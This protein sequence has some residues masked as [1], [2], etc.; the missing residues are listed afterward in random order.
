MVRD[1]FVDGLFTRIVPEYVPTAS[2]VTLTETCTETG[3]PDTTVPET[4][5]TV[6]QPP[7]EVVLTVI[8]KLRLPPPEL[9]T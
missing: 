1:W 6:S 5:D 9:L 7:P 4:G 8:T 2:P 3:E